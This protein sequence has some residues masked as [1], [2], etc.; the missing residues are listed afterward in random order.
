MIDI[1]ARP[2]L[3]DWAL[4]LGKEAAE[5]HRLKAAADGKRLHAHIAGAL[6]EFARGETYA[7]IDPDDDDARATQDADVLEPAFQWLSDNIDWGAD[8]LSE[9]TIVGVNAGYAGTVDIFAYLRTGK[10]AI[11]DMKTKDGKPGRS[12]PKPY[13]DKEG[14]Q[15]AGYERLVDEGTLQWITMVI[16]R[17]HTDPKIRIYQWSTAEKRRA[18]EAFALLSQLWF[19]TK[20]YRPRPT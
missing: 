10:W 3:V 4:K 9:E 6:E 12:L 2:G 13:L 16:N 15:L 20:D 17:D 19:V 7:V 14:L 5:A 18:R 8:V 11:V 1:I